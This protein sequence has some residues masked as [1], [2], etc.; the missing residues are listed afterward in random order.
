MLL[1]HGR[2]RRL[3][4][5]RLTAK[6]TPQLRSSPLFSLERGVEG[7]RPGPG[8]S[9]VF[10]PGDW[11]SDLSVLG[12]ANMHSV[13]SWEYVLIGKSAGWHVSRARVL[14]VSVTYLA[15]H[16]GC[17]VFFLTAGGIAPAKGGAMGKFLL[18]KSRWWLRNTF[19]AGKKLFMWLCSARL[20]LLVL[21]R[22]VR[23]NWFSK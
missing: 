23:S 12:T 2:L 1:P 9:R 17:K 20:S 4:H 3:A 22:L 14:L 6:A 7:M 15:G 19:P 8:V 18:P 21:G 11:F 5:A 10:A 16:L 13:D